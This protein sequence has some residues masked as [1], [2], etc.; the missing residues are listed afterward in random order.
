MILV[1]ATP[2]DSTSGV[3]ASKLRERGERVTVLA[4]DAFP[5]GAGMSIRLGPRDPRGVEAKTEVKL[6]LT[7]ALDG[8]TNVG[9]ASGDRVGAWENRAARSS[10]LDLA[11]VGVIW[12]R[13][14]PVVNESARA[15]DAGRANLPANAA[16]YF[17][18]EATAFY[19]AALSRAPSR[20]VWVPGSFDAI[21]LANDKAGQLHRAVRAGFEIPATLITS[22]PAELLEFYREHRGRVVSKS[23]ANHYF[24]SDAQSPAAFLD[25][26]AV[27]RRRLAAYQTIRACPAI[28]QAMVPKAYELRVTVIGDRA[29]AC[30]IHTQ[31]ANHTRYDSRRFDAANT[32]HRP[33][34]LPESLSTLC[35]AFVREH[36]LSY[37]GFDFIVTPDGRYVFLEMNAN[38]EYRWLEELTR[39]P[40]TDAMVDH[41]IAAEHGSLP[42]PTLEAGH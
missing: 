19:R 9:R 21:A 20:T 24:P 31:G 3:V 25:T 27:S 4:H 2:G 16:R 12:A 30:E 7:P 10:T 6:A 28:F 40:M 13:A 5:A 23:F 35:R 39:M 38:G 15:S 22:I 17:D 11:E 33:H 32:A 42:T 26:R 14:L 29:F 18:D 8:E 34:A 37:A 41:L 1:L 36:R